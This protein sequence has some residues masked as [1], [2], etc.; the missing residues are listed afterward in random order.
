[1]LGTK[2]GGFQADRPI[3]RPDKE[4]AA[5]SEQ[6][7]NNERIVARTPSPLPDS[8]EYKEMF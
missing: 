2:K 6:D 1:M 7:D 5:D 4:V 3:S 8:E